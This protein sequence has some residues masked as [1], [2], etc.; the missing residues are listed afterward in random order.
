MLYGYGNYRLFGENVPEALKGLPG[1]MLSC[2]P[3]IGPNEREI[4]AHAQY[5][6]I[7]DCIYAAR[8]KPTFKSTSLPFSFPADH[9]ALPCKLQEVEESITASAAAPKKKARLSGAR[10]G[11]VDKASA[12]LTREQLFAAALERNS[13]ARAAATAAAADSESDREGEGE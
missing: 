3:P 5:R 4:V 7:L 8:Q 2:A 11:G 12:P 13:L 6:F 1:A 9:N 10:I